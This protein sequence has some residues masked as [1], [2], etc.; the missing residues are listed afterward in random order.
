MTQIT[1]HIRNDDTP[2]L[3]IARIA[4]VVANGAM[5]S[6]KKGPSY[7]ALTTFND[8]PMVECRR[9]KHGYSFFVTTPTAVTIG[10][11]SPTT[12]GT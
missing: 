4:R 1:I 8:G 3:A 5:S 11:Q 12:E 10:V 7:C 6:S 9:T 2:E